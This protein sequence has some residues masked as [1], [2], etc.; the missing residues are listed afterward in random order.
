MLS[1]D[2]KNRIATDAQGVCMIL[3]S[4]CLAALV[5]CLSACVTPKSPPPPPEASK[6]VPLET[7]LQVLARDLNQA[8][9]VALSDVQTPLGKQQLKD[10]VF[11]RQCAIKAA[12]PPLPVIT[13]PVSLQLQGTFTQQNQEQIQIGFPVAA[14]V[15]F[16]AQLS[17]AQQ[18]QL[19]VPISF[20]AAS[21]LANFFL[22]QNLPNLS[23]L[24]D[25]PD[26]KPKNP[27]SEKP[28]R[29]HAKV[30][31]NK[32]LPAPAKPESDKDV[33]GRRKAEFQL[34]LIAKADAIT[35]AVKEQIAAYPNADCKNAPQGQGIGLL[36]ELPISVVLPQGVPPQ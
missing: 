27:E 23:T 21:A 19:T 13:G 15:Q 35:A 2:E 29:G 11:A 8:T 25:K 10:A 28:A 22:G 7:A 34:A 36:P 24:P 4:L 5:A 33:L 9:P 31:S 12:D 16:Q 26:E 1:A 18:Q 20:V 30:G 6:W 14:S 3:R 32:D 17:K